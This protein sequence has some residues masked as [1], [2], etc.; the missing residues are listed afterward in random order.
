LLRGGG[1]LVLELGHKSAPY[2][3]P[4]LQ[5]A[6]WLHAAMERDLAGIDRVVSAQRAPR[7]ST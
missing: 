4:L 7:D 5:G 1:W 2:I 3:A 6:P